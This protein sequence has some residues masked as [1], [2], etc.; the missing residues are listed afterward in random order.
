LALRQDPAE[1]PSGLRTRVLREISTA[2]VP[3]G[4]TPRT[5][6]SARSTPR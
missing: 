6:S 4:F 3:L 1:A 5:A 2:A